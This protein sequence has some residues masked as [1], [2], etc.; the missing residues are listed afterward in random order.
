MLYMILTKEN[1]LFH[2]ILMKSVR[3]GLK[4]MVMILICV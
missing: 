2:Q 4:N 1:I 3:N